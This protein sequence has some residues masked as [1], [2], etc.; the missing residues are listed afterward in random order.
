MK[1]LSVIILGLLSCSQTVIA[2]NMYSKLGI[3]VLNRVQFDEIPDWNHGKARKAME[4]LHNSCSIIK[5]QPPRAYN[6]DMTM[7][8]WNSLCHGILR[9]NVKAAKATF[10]M[11]FDAYRVTV[12]GD[13]NAK[14]LLTGYYTPLLQ[15]SFEQ[16]EKYQVPVYAL[17]EKSEDQNGFTREQIDNGAL[18]NKAKILMWLD[19][20]IELF[21][22]HIQGSGYVKMTDGSTQKLSFAGKNNFP[23]TAIGK[24]FVEQ[25]LVSSE[26]ISM[27]WL[28]NWLRDNPEN[29]KSV[30]W[31]NQS[32]IFFENSSANTRIRGAE[33]TPLKAMASLAVDP[34]Y[35]SY[36]IPVYVHTKMKD[37]S[38]FSALAVAQDTGSAIKGSLRADLYTGIGTKAGE[39]AGRLKEK[40]DFYVFYPRQTSLEGQ[41]K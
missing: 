17:P 32:Y 37:G 12:N 7:A 5:K 3:P 40:A 41:F 20:P 25:G 26:E 21:F 39:L 13:N 19:D 2:Q 11:Y 33:S 24:Q 18:N 31:R 30:M 23:Y 28:K 10:E 38:S 36:G 14:G 8:A 22:L 9:R 27:Q 6:L 16:T 29:A 35:I 4:A 15:G 34:E 1:K